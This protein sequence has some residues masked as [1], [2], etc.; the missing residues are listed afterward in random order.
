PRGYRAPAGRAGLR[1]H[2]C[3]TGRG[4]RRPAHGGRA[5]RLGHAPGAGDADAR[6][7]GV[8]PAALAG[9]V[10]VPDARRRLGRRCPPRAGGT[11]DERRGRPMNPAPIVD[12]SNDTIWITLIKGAV[13]L[14]FLLLS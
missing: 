9:L 14:V 1:R 3:G 7:R 6:P 12:F 13:I 2:R 4:R 8:A 10:A 11:R 5:A